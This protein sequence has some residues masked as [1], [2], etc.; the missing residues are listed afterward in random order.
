MSKFEITCA[1]EGDS[2]VLRVAGELDLASYQSI[3]DRVVP[4]LTRGQTTVLDLDRLTF[5]DASGLRAL[6]A[7]VQTSRKSAA[8]VAVRHARGQVA[9]LL[10]AAGFGSLIVDETLAASAT[11]HIAE[12]SH[13]SA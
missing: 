12:P 1:M 13:K 6:A 7:C 11:L 10:K 8:R 3:V 4:A 2:M 5:I 9:H